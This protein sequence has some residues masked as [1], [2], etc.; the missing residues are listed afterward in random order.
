MGYQQLANMYSMVWCVD[1][2]LVPHQRHWVVDIL[3]VTGLAEPTSSC[4]SATNIKFKCQFNSTYVHYH[5]SITADPSTWT[6]ATGIGVILSTPSYCIG[7]SSDLNHRSCN[8]NFSQMHSGRDKICLWAGSC[9]VE[10]L[11]D[12]LPSSL[13]WSRFV[14]VSCLYRNSIVLCYSF[15]GDWTLHIYSMFHCRRVC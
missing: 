1:I 2:F 3:K 14:K 7:Y 10:K 15:L 11:D 9:K 13:N 5:T 4:P 6:K 12:I 8:G